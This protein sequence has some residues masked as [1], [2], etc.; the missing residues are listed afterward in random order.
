M[1][2]TMLSNRRGVIATLATLAALFSLQVGPSSGEPAPE[3]ISKAKTIIAATTTSQPPPKSGAKVKKPAKTSK[4]PTR[5]R[6]E[7]PCRAWTPATSPK[8]VL[9]CV[10]GLGLNSRS[11][12]PF[13][14]RMAKLGV[15]T[16]AV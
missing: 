4:T 6:I 16:F 9:L 1:S 13:G 8:V 5:L 3:S 15:A 12:E 10:H 7:V 14:Q 11:Y 2:H